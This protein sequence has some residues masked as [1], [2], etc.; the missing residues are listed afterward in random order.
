MVT[1][2][3]AV[4]VV[5]IIDFG[6][7]KATEQRLTE[8][9]FFTAY[10]QVIGTPAYMSPEQASMSLLDVEMHSDVYSLGVL[11]YELLTGTTPI[12][13]VRLREAGFTDIQRMIRDVSPPRPSTRLSSLGNSATIV[14]GNRGTDPRQLGRLL[15]G[16]LDWIVMKAI[17]KDRNRRY[18]S[19]GS[20]ADDVERFLR[21]EAIVGP[22]AINSLSHGQIRAAASC[23]C[24]H[25]RGRDG[26]VIGRDSDRRLAGNRGDAGQTPRL[27]AA[28]AEGQAKQ[29]AMA[30]EAE[31]RAVLM[32]VEN[33]ILAA[34]RPKGR[35]GGLGPGVTL[36]DAIDAAIPFVE[37]GF[38]TSRHRGPPPHDPGRLVLVLS[39]RRQGGGSSI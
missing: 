7:S 32:F 39:R 10:G 15:A 37:T 29:E 20:F 31:T 33:H 36:R 2:N 28:V 12:E 23:G 17:E 35:R 16:D 18:S 26:G 4:P 11:L 21:H 13:A 19:P 30:K 5:K 8:K 27:A 24:A 34:A 1:L 6:V 14:A 3:D 9:T 25:A 38:R 22:A